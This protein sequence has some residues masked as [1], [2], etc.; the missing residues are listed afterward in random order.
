[1]KITQQIGV[2][3]SKVKNVPQSPTSETI[4]AIQGKI[5]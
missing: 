4:R 3:F 1:M 5:T 2:G